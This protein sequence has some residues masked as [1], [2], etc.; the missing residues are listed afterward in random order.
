MTNTLPSKG[1]FCST[2]AI[3]ALAIA[4]ILWRAYTR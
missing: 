2:M 4:A 1:E 3:F